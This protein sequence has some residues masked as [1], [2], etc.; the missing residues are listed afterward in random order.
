[1]S[2]WGLGVALLFLPVAALLGSAA[3]LAA[4]V[5]LVGSALNTA[6]GGFSYSINQSAKE[7]LYVPTTREEKYKA[8]AFIDMFV[9]RFAK[10]VA[11][12][13]SLLITTWFTGFDSLRWLSLLTMGVLV[14][15]IIAARYAG[16]VFAQKEA[17][18]SS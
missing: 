17:A 16:R 15:W 13:L 6:D 2:R 14:L 11:V 7:A 10:A 5:L 3:F 9:Q 12:G 1:M 18:A 8:K 4:P